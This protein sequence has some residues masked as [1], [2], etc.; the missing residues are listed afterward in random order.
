MP[1]IRLNDADIHYIE[2][3]TGPE[4][5]VFAHGLLFSRAIFDEQIRALRDRYRCIAFDFRGHGGSE[6]TESGYDMDSL[7]EDTAALI[8][9]LHCAPCHFVGLS[10]GGFVG[11]RLAIRHGSLLKSLALLD[12]SADGEA[13]GERIRFR[14]MNFIA[15]YFGMQLVIDR[16]MPLMFGPRFLHDS[17][18]KDR[19]RTAVLANDRLGVSRAVAGV[20]GRKSVH[21]QL[22]AISVPTLVVI[23]EHD[24][25]TAPP[26]SVR[27][28]QAIPGA[29]LVMLPGAGHMS[30][31]EDPETVSR[32]LLDFFTSVS[33]RSPEPALV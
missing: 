8:E 15:R 32:T 30:S 20:V 13:A 25:L 2:Q 9:T 3:G 12:S 24:Q 16:I 27:M 6:V 21:D 11:L 4:A 7:T 17:E 28:Q 14:L 1:T 29:R 23:G 22:H 26:H 10:M 19:W 18:R 33:D 31:I 5:V